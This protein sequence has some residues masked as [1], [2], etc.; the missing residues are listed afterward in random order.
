MPDF[1]AQLIMTVLQLINSL[2]HLE[3]LKAYSGETCGC[4][5]SS[6]FS[7]LMGKFINGITD[8][9]SQLGDWNSLVM[10]FFQ[11]GMS[12]SKSYV[13]SYM[14]NSSIQVQQYS[15]PMGHACVPCP[16]PRTRPV[17]QRQYVDPC[18]CNPCGNG[19]HPCC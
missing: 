6:L 8:L 14:P 1:L 3:G 4:L 2:A 12:A 10:A 16:T 17:I 9:Q 15:A 11:M 18:G 19:C 7:L 13:A 5:G